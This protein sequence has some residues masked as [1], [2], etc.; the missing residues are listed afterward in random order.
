MNVQVQRFGTHH[1]SLYPHMCCARGTYIFTS[2]AGKP[3]CVYDKR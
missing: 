2:H 1:R 3:L